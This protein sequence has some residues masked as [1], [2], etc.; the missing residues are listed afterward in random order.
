M[1]NS[2]GKDNDPGYHLDIGLKSEIERRNMEEYHKKQML[3]T[4]DK[5][6]QIKA[7]EKRQQRQNSLEADEAN[8]R[9]QYEQFDRRRNQGKKF[10]QNENVYQ[11]YKNLEE[12]KRIREREFE[13]R[14]VDEAAVKKMEEEDYKRYI[15]EKDKEMKTHQMKNTLDLQIDIHNRKVEQE[16][17]VNPE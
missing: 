14:I 2:R 12:D 10:G 13:H 1:R 7:E 3:D 9:Y 15:K 17:K 4:L 8:L 11:Y 6:L 5:Q 16:K